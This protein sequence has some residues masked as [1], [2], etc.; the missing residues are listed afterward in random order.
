MNV[1]NS[2]IKLFCYQ[3]AHWQ[4]VV[5]Q[6]VMVRTQCHTHKELSGNPPTNRH[7]QRANFERKCAG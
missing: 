3:N 6:N 5:Y 7:E 1:L 2:V 4:R